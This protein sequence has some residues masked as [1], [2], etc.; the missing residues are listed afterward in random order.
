MKQEKQ[1]KPQR[2]KKARKPLNLKASFQTRSF[3]VGGYSVV[4]TAI[5]LAII[6]AVNLIVSALPEKYTKL[7]TTSNQLFTLSDQTKSLVSNL[8]QEGTI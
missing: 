2:Q 3:R 8:P 1:P 7:D 6:I 5:V 4:A